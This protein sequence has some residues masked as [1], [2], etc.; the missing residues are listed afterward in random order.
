MSATLK[1]EV[2]S[3]AEQVDLI[4]PIGKPGLSINK[5]STTG[6]RQTALGGGLYMI[7]LRF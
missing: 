3:D 7:P 6:S 2:K 5:Q 4:W 1:N